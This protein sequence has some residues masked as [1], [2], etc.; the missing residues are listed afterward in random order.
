MRPPHTGDKGVLLGHTLGI[1]AP[2]SQR[3]GKH[4]FTG[5]ADAYDDDTRYASEHATPP[6][7]L[8]SWRLRA[9]VTAGFIVS[10]FSSRYV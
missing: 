9:Q 4:R 1:V 6:S 10:R 8:C 2:L 3:V 5:T 7:P